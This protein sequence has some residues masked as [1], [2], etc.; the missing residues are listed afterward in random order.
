MNQPHSYKSELNKQLK[1]SSRSSQLL[2]FVVFGA[3][4]LVAEHFQFPKQSIGLLFGVV[5]GSMM[6]IS[7]LFRFFV[8]CRNCAAPIV[9]DIPEFSLKNAGEALKASKAAQEGPLSDDTKFCFCCGLDFEKPPNQSFAGMSA[10]NIYLRIPSQEKKLL[11]CNLM[12][13]LVGFSL[14]GAVIS[15]LEMGLLPK[16]EPSTLGV[17]ALL[18]IIS[19][20]YY[21]RNSG[22]LPNL[23]CGVCHRKCGPTLSTIYNRFN[24]NKPKFCP[25]CGAGLHII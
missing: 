20:Y 6:A 2:F 15:A 3:S 13:Y 7:Q 5:M 18:I 11:V 14:I 19:Y 21:R 1:S 9:V 22:Q 17:L 12:F 24:T 8:R 25:S 4:L 16:P 10:R 23:V